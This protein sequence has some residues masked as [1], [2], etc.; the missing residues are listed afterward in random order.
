M[1]K[2]HKQTNK[3]NSNNDNKTKYRKLKL[4]NRATKLVK[5]NLKI[6]H[7]SLQG[8]KHRKK[9]KQHS[10][11][12]NICISL[13]WIKNQKNPTYLLSVD[14]SNHTNGN[15]HEKSKDSDYQ[16]LLTDRKKS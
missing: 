8:T 1:L 6:I 7:G 15:L 13:M 3:Q 16:K 9:T 2:A 4:G 12:E 11:K 14:E 10:W 5:E